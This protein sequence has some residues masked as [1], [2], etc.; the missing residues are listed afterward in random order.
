[1]VNAPVYFFRPQAV[2][3]SILLLECGGPISNSTQGA[4]EKCPGQ[5]DVRLASPPKEK[6]QDKE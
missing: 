5:S 2:E 3:G 1:M 6:K 4:L